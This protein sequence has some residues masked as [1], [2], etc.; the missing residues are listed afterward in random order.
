MEGAEKTKDKFIHI[1]R[2]K[3][4]SDPA[5][6]KMVLYIASEINDNGYCEIISGRFQTIFGVSRQ[7]FRE[8]IKKAE[9]KSA[10]SSTAI[11]FKYGCF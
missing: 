3:A 11:K 6:L 10:Y 7:K 9:V 4:L 5:M 1:P 8:L 2:E